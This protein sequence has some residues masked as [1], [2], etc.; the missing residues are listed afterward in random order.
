M[1]H[2]QGNV[3]NGVSAR[4]ERLVY[5][6]GQF[7]D[8]ELEYAFS[9]HLWEMAPL[10]NEFVGDPAHIQGAWNLEPQVP[11]KAAVSVEMGGQN[12]PVLLSWSEDDGARAV[13]EEDR[14]IAAA[15]CVLD[16]GGVD[17]GADHQH[18]LVCADSYER[19]G[20]GEAINEARTLVAHVKGADAFKPKLLLQDAG[21][22]GEEEVRIERREYDEVYFLEVDAGRLCGFLCRRHGQVCRTDAVLHISPF[23]DA[24]PL[25]DPFVARIKH[26]REIVICN[27]ALRQIL[28]QAEY[29]CSWHF[30]FLLSR[31]LIL[32][33]VRGSPRAQRFDSSKQGFASQPKAVL[34]GAPGGRLLD[35]THHFEGGVFGLGIGDHNQLRAGPADRME[36]ARRGLDDELHV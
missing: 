27:N 26:F 17:L 29:C 15:V 31:V 32:T 18:L 9:I 13:A 4:L 7:L 14:H 16:A 6:L 19:I 10:L 11:C 28:A 3:I 1:G 34:R 2:K 21:G 25:T 30:M 24:R 5:H 22:A 36:F 8:G 12:P 23:D 33:C 20:D 35:T